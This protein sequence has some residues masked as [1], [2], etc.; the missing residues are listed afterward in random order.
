MLNKSYKTIGG[1]NIYGN[2]H[3]RPLVYGYELSD[4]EK[5]EFDYIDNIDEKFTGFRYKNNVYDLNEFERIEKNHP[6]F[7][8]FDGYISDSFFSGI[9]IKLNCEDGFFEFVKVYT[10]IS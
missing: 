4:K 8:V 2:N 1:T 7:N 3:N 5:K 10:F 6:F 9:G